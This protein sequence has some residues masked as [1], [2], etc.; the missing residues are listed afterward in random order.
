MKVS[1]PGGEL[2]PLAGHEAH[3][4]VFIFRQSAEDIDGRKAIP[5]DSLPEHRLGVARIMANDFGVGRTQC[6]QPTRV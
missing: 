1:L 4:G 6:I 2:K 5:A 3:G